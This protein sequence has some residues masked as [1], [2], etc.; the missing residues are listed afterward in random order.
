MV[1]GMYG[2]VLR[3]RYIGKALDKGKHRL[4]AQIMEESPRG[5]GKF[6]CILVGG[7][8]YGLALHWVSSELNKP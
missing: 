4:P 3:M 1:K 5:F 2:P 8:M 6:E 7:G